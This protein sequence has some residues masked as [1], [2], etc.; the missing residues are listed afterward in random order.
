MFY[1]VVAGLQAGTYQISFMAAQRGNYPTGAASRTSTSSS[2]AGLST[3]A[4]PMGPSYARYTTVTFAL[5][6]AT[7]GSSSR[8]NDMAGGDNTAFIDDVMLTRIPPTQPIGNAGFEVPAVGAATSSSTARPALTGSSSVVCR[9]LAQQQRLHLR[10][11]PRTRGGS[12]R[13]P[14]GDRLVQPSDRRLAGRHL[15]DQL[16]GR[17]A[18]QPPGQQ[19]GLPGPG[20]WQYES[21][22]FTPT[23]TAY[24][25][26]RT[27]T[28]VVTAGAHTIKFQGIDSRGGDNTAFIDAVTLTRIATTPTI[29]NAGLEVA[30]RRRREV[31]VPPERR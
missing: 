26:L 21:A 19:A 18:G 28:F 13:L 25:S 1:Q 17:P 23:G 20:R 6:Q 24:A 9:H 27:A 16:Q 12:G 14:P 29:A 15:P 8:A 10:Q 2:M 4:R 7:I 31:P 11:P 22:T 5:R 30:G 3:A